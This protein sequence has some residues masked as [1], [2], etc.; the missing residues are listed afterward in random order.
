MIAF[1]D[2]ARR[3][4]NGVKLI[5]FKYMSWNFVQYFPGLMQEIES[6]YSRIPQ[7]VHAWNSWK[8]LPYKDRVLTALK[9]LSHFGRFRTF[10]NWLMYHDEYLDA[11]CQNLGNKYGNGRLPVFAEKVRE[12]MNQDGR[13]ISI[14]ELADTF[15]FVYKIS[16][17]GTKDSHVDRSNVQRLNNFIAAV[18][19][20]FNRNYIAHECRKIMD[21]LFSGDHEVTP[22]EREILQVNG[23]FS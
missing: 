17:D 13:N 7:T 1:T 22:E 18:L 14:N 19:D 23:W 8:R 9:K 10:L 6:E 20:L 11:T 3:V 2:C 15:M 4:R 21:D 5:Q 16:C 12:L